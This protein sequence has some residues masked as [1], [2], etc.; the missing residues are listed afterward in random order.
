MAGLAGLAA[1]TQPATL[2]ITG[3]ALLVA[4]QPRTRSPA[5]RLK[6]GPTRRQLTRDDGESGVDH[7]RRWRARPLLA[8]VVFATFYYG[9]PVPMPVIA[10]WTERAGLASRLQARHAVVRV[11]PAPRSA[12]ARRSSSRLSSWRHG[13]A[14]A[15]LVR[16]RGAIVAYTSIL[17]LWAGDGMPGRWLALPVSRV[18]ADRRAAS[19]SWCGPRVAGGIR[20][21]A[22]ALAAVP[23]LAPIQSDVRFGTS[24]PVTEHRDPRVADYPATGLLLDIRQW[25][26]PHHPEA[27]RGGVAWQDT[28]RVKTSPHPAFFGFAAGYGVHVIDRTGRTDPLLARLRPD[29]APAFPAGADA[30]D[31]GRIRGVAAGQGQSPSRIPRSLRT[32]IACGSSRAGPLGDPRRLI[33][34]LR[35]A[36]ASPPEPSPAALGVPGVPSSAHEREPRRTRPRRIRW[37]TCPTTPPVADV[38]RMR[39]PTASLVA[40][41]LLFAAVVLR[42]A[43]VSDDAF[44]TFRTVDNALNGDG[45]RWNPAERVQTYTHPLWMLLLLA[46]TAI[47]GNPYLSSLGLSFVLTACAV[48]LLL[49]TRDGARALGVRA[50]RDHVVERVRGLLDERPRER[51][52]ARATRCAAR[53]VCRVR[54]IARRPRFR[55]GMIV[56]LIGTTRLDLL[57][58]AAPLALGSLRRWRRTLPWFTLGL[59]PLAAWEVFSVVYYGVPFPNTAYAK[60]ATGIPQPELLHQGFVYLLDSLN[61][62]PVTLL[63]IVTAV[64]VQLSSATLRSWVPGLA[65]ALYLVYVV[66]IGGDFMSGRF[67]TAPFFVALT[68]LMR[69]EWPRAP[70]VQAAPAMAVLALGL[71]AP[72]PLPRLLFGGF[73][74]PIETDLAAERHRGR[75]ALLLPAHGAPHAA[76]DPHGSRP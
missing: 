66:R 75:A 30:A 74:Q 8:W 9:T 19:A 40:L 21:A 68:L 22:I 37:S 45:L 39:R 64:A 55:R 52:V 18:H 13:A 67:L 65:L 7:R 25:Y 2:L 72:G 29:R 43:W 76:R 32:T 69:A 38:A 60:L 1:L 23:A 12:H 71:S 59:W 33:A 42:T 31:A 6:S 34:A 62:D 58:L 50:R 24:D 27:T 17:A 73:P 35:L 54:P 20:G 49:R 14:A 51:A 3:P 48:L 70:A 28:N 57:V 44:I 4:T 10:E 61:R 46:T 63:V 5:A 41:A 36:F 56:A 11:R 53:G 47:T 16:S 26:P 15:A